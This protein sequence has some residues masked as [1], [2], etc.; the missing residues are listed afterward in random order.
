MA[1]RIQWGHPFWNGKRKDFTIAIVAAALMLILLFL[2]NISY[3]YG[4]IFNADTRTKA[5]N[6]LAVDFDGGVT[7]QSIRAA[8]S[9]LQ[10]DNFPTL[11][12]ESIARYPD[13]QSLRNAVCHGDYWGAT[14][15]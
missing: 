13:V 2:A 3:L 15:S 4:F 12:F 11:N 9:E 14:F 6:I 10:S 1:G 5:L 7:G 8:Y